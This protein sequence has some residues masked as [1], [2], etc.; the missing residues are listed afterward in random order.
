MADT[1]NGIKI[2]QAPSYFI[3]TEEDLEFLRGLCLPL[4]DPNN[5]SKLDKEAISK[6]YSHKTCDV[7]VYILDFFNSLK[8]HSDEAFEHFHD[9]YDAFEKERNDEA[10]IFAFNPGSYE[11][12]N[13]GEKLLK[14]V[15]I[16]GYLLSFFLLI[17]ILNFYNKIYN[18]K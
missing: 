14:R 1:F 12:V 6:G 17:I 5:P 16:L 10:A 15:N 2:I 4:A 8:N 11:F 7:Y 3:N 9:L 18:L 13:I